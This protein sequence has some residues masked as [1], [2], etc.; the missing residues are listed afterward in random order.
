M[1]LIIV[2]DGLYQLIPVTKEIMEGIVITADV[3]CFDLCDILRLKLTGYV[4][5]LNL[6]LMN[7]GSGNFV[8][9]MCR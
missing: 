3:S 1:D 4:D 9:C 2:N 8:G 6:H 5:T 7:D